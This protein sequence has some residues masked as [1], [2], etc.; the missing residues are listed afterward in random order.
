MRLG[1]LGGS[2][3]PIHN[4][5]LTIA[6]AARDTHK[7]DRVLFIPAGQAPQKKGHIASTEDRLAMVR[8][9]IEGRPGFEVSDIELQREGKSFTVDTLEQLK[10]DD[11]ELFFILG[12]DS[13][14]NLLSW[15]KPQRIL[16]LARVVV[17]NRPG[18]ATI[19]K[20]ED[21]PGLSQQQID[22]LKADRVWTIPSPIRSRDIRE[23]IR[24]SRYI[25][26]SVP[27]IVVDYIKSHKLYM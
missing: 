25:A 17:V 3:D 23:D 22:Q 10:T 24:L 19:L 11:N 14:Q 16:T 5:H 7:L 8:L 27:N 2:F 26:N 4:G 9:A 21:F 20:Q 1:I 18:S 12:E 13:I 15:Y 6:E